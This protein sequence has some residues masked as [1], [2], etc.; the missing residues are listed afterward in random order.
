MQIS[1]ECFRVLAVLLNPERFPST[2]QRKLELPQ[3]KTKNTKRRFRWRGFQK[4]V[5]LT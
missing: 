1:F 5:F 2:Q 4:L 3:G